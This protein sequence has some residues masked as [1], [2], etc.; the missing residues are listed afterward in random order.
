MRHRAQSFF[1]LLLATCFCGA[2]FAQSITTDK[3][4]YGLD[5]TVTIRF[6]YGKETDYGA[7][8]GVRKLSGQGP[9]QYDSN[10]YD[11]PT[12]TKTI[13]DHRFSPGEYEAVLVYT[14]EGS[15]CHR[16]VIARTTFVVRGP[17]GEWIDRSDD[18]SAPLAKFR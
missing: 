8:V 18:F 1:C 2:A 11:Q 3:K 17:G 13:S 6:S 4:V 12:G 9:G 7:F 15:D 14:C 10:A 5:D 16:R